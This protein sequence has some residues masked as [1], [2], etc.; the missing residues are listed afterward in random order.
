MKL[1]ASPRGRLV[2]LSGVVPVLFAAA[3]ALYRPPFF[4]RL[5]D[6]TYDSV[7]RSA[8]TQKPAGRVAIVDVD[9]RSLAAIGQWPWRRDVMGRLITS[10]RA[11]GASVIAIDVIFA[12]SD[13]YSATLPGSHPEGAQVSPDQQ[14]AGVL[15]DNSVVLGYG[16]T[17]DPGAPSR[18]G[19]VLRP[20]DPA[21]ITPP[22]GDTIEPFFR[23]TGAVC[24]LPVLAEAAARSGFLNAA[25]DSDGILR[26]IPLLAELDGRVYPSL[27][28]ASVIAAT[29]AANPVLHVT[30]VNAATLT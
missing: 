4:A 11:A 12:E 18:R 8:G 21:V 26:R 15:R 2:F 7:V 10:L 6:A 13:R 3:L 17:F 9:E 14:L 28:L 27:A 22:G 25:P 29:G 19:C 1:P 20:L 23:A 30:T 16:L 24:N 5:D